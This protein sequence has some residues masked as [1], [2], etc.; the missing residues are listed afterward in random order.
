MRSLLKHLSIL[1]LVRIADSFG[2]LMISFVIAAM[3]IPNDKAGLLAGIALAGMLVGAPLMGIVADKKGRRVA[4]SLSLFIYSFFTLISFRLYSYE[5]LLA[6]RFLA[7]VG[8]GGVLPTAST[9]FIEMAPHERRGLYVSVFESMRAV[10]SLIVTA[11]A[12][13]IIPKFGR[14]YMFLV[15]SFPIVLIPL[16]LTMTETP[17]Y[18]ASRG[19]KE[20]A[21]RV[22]E[23]LGIEIDVKIVHENHEL[24]SFKRVTILVSLIRFSLALAYYGRTLRAPRYL[25]SIGFSLKGSMKYLIYVSLAMIAGYYTNAILVDTVGRRKLLTAYIFLSSIALALFSMHVC[26]FVTGLLF[27]SL[28]AA[29]R[30]VAYTYTPELYPTSIRGTA[31]GIAGASARIGG[32]LGPVILGLYGSFVPIIAFLILSSIAA[33]LVGIETARKLLNRIFILLIRNDERW[34][35]LINDERGLH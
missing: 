10:G 15:G 3:D 17:Y 9:A 18:L 7:G 12:Y 27:A 34:S 32:F 2:A 25:M 30:C 29:S 11:T 28:N 19:Y 35:P 22:A 13:V 5:R 4:I 31:M 33:R 14:R 1:S 6:L 8:I 16:V 23:E 26:V 20:E 21:R 24:L